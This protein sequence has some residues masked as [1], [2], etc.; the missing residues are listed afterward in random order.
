MKILSRII[1]NHDD[2]LLHGL[3]QHI[4]QII[5]QK[6]LGMVTTNPYEKQIRSR[7]LLAMD[8]AVNL[9]NQLNKLFE[10]KMTREEIAYLALHFQSYLERTRTEAAGINVILVCSSG[11]GSALLLKQKLQSR[12]NSKLNKITCLSVGDVMLR[13]KLQADLIVSTIPIAELSDVVVVSPMLEKEDLMRLDTVISQKCSINHSNGD[14]FKLFHEDAVII[15]NDIAQ[16]KANAIKQLVS[17]LNSYG[18]V[19][20][21]L[22]NSALKRE[23][24]SSTR[25]GEVAI[26]HGNPSYVKKPVI[27]ILINPHGIT[28]DDKKVKLVFFLATK[29]Q[30]E[31]GLERVYLH[32]LELIQKQKEIGKLS[33]AKDSASVLKILAK[34]YQ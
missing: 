29:T 1:L 24:L 22:Y 13:R 10:I 3:A 25:L 28:W 30:L 5:Y 31:Q 7:Y 16:T 33:E 17:Q 32:F 23:R 27:G 2:I 34:M 8:N 19:S 26:P 14:F 21:K 6:N 12:Y 20:E 15:S 9:A 4:Q 18:Y 11:R